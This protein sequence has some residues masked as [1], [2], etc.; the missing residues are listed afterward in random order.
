MKD[1]A[2]TMIRHPIATVIVLGSITEAAVRVISA[3][4][5]FSVPPLFKFEVVKGAK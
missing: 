4:S 5:G 2:N 1:L 3:L